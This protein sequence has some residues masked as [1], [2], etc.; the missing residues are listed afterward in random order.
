MHARTAMLNAGPGGSI[1]SLQGVAEQ[2]QLR[3]LAAQ[4]QTGKETL[5]GAR[6]S[7]D[8][9]YAAIGAD[10]RQLRAR[11]PQLLNSA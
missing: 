7:R 10:L 1:H 3:T 8:G 2:P 4:W 11:L 6:P 5:A 9:A